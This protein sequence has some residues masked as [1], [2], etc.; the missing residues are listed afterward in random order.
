MTIPCS[1]ATLSIPFVA[2]NATEE[3]FGCMVSLLKTITDI[4]QPPACRRGRDWCD[5]GCRD[6]DEQPYVGLMYSPSQLGRRL[7]PNSATDARDIVFAVFD[8]LHKKASAKTALGALSLEDLDDLRTWNFFERDELGAEIEDLFAQWQEHHRQQ[9]IAQ[10]PIP[11]PSP[12]R[13]M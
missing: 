9:F 3:G 7:N 11:S 12:S 5:L 2:T 13:K 8:H 1:T 10:L 6:H 4:H